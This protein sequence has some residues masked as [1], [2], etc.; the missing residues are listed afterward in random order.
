ML[1]LNALPVVLGTLLLTDLFVFDLL[2]VD[3]LEFDLTGVL[4]LFPCT[5][6]R[7]GAHAFSLQ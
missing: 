4:L 1:Y 6:L 7:T 5:V 3:I 2:G